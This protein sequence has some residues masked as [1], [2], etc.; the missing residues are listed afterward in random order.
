MDGIEKKP[1]QTGR[2]EETLE[3]KN[4]KLS[5]EIMMRTLAGT[6]HGGCFGS[7]VKRGQT[8]VLWTCPQL[9]C[10]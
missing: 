2:Q 8:K 1:V 7:E 6:A 10:W 9:I 5:L 4:L 3:T